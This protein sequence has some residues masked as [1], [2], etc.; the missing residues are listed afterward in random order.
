[1]CYRTGCCCYRWNMKRKKKCCRKRSTDSVARRQSWKLRGRWNKIAWYTVRKVPLS[2]HLF[3]LNYQGRFYCCAMS[4]VDCVL[5]TV[6]GF[7]E[8]ESWRNK[9]NQLGIEPCRCFSWSPAGRWSWH[10]QHCERN[11]VLLLVY[12]FVFLS[13]S[14]AF[15]CDHEWETTESFSVWLL[16]NYK[17]PKIETWH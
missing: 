10:S 12:C 5:L 14:W 8:S 2:S 1:M 6:A 4:A 13:A 9:E 11:L 16:R 17:M 7:V 15:N 3:I